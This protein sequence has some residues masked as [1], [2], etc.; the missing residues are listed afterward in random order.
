MTKT[1]LNLGPVPHAQLPTKFGNF[2]IFGFENPEDGEEAVAVVKG[3]LSPDS[4][5]LVRIHSQCLT[6]DVFHSLR[7]DCGDQ[8]QEAL[9]KIH[10]SGC[11]LLIYQMQEGRGIGL[12]NKLYAYELQDR[13]IDTVEANVKLGFEAD[14]RS[15]AFCA[16]ILR[17]FGL[18][19]I[20]LLSNNPEK[21]RGVE[22]HGIEVVER[23]PLVVKP[24]AISEK[25]LKTKKE[26]MGHLL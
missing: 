7:C 18:T 12:I 26:K 17:Y 15:Y 21:I 11:G 16:R 19:R 13:G 3:V 20:R 4:I 1:Q 25:Y 9:I 2:E 6:G 5:P 24:S 14:Q 22:E 8:L 10:G 23:V